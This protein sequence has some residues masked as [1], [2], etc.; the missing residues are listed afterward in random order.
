MPVFHELS[1]FMKRFLP[2]FLAIAALGSLFLANGQEKE[3]SPPE[4][5]R[6]LK[7]LLI[8]GGCCHDYVK[9]HEILFKGIQERANV[10]VDVVWTRDRSTNPP[11]PIYDDPDW[12][13]GYDIIIHDE[14]AANNKD[15]KVMENILAVHKTIPSVHLHCAMHSFR[16]GTDKWPKHLGIHSTGHGPQKPLEITYTNPDHPI[17]KTLKDWTTKNEEL[18]NNHKIY[19]AEPL[20]LATQKNGDRE[21]SAI[22]AW[23][24]TKQ[25]APSFSTTIGHNNYTVEDP[26]Y[27][28]L[29]TRGLLWAAGKLNDDYLKPY[30]GSNLITEMANAAKPVAEAK[31]PK[32][33]TMVKVT[34]KNV[35]TDAGHFPWKAIDGDFSTRWTGNG[36]TMPNWLQLEFQKPTTVTSAEIAWEKRKDWYQ[37][38][39]ETSLDGKS[40]QMA[41]DGS[42]NQRQSDTKDTFEAENI[43]FLRVTVL[44]HQHGQWP[45][46]W[47]L[48][49][50][51]EKGPLKLFPIFEKGKGPKSKVSGKGFEQS[52][53]IKPRIVKLTPEEE[54]AILKDTE[55]PEGFEKTLFAPW[56]TANYPVYVAASP[57]GDLYVSSDGNGSLG[58]QPGRGRVLR[59]R[60]TDQDGRADEVTE[61]IR[62]IDSPRGLIWDHDRLYLLHPPHISVFFDRDGDGVAEES[63][64]LISD[65][66]FG[67]EDR[68]AD[69]TT[70]D[71]TMG[72]DGWIYIA[73]G[74]FGF[75]KATGSDGRTLQHRGGGVIRFRPDGSG[76]ELFATGTRNILATPISPTLDMFARDNTNDG[77]GWDVRFHH[78][79]ALSDHG[80]PRLY[81]NFEKEH[82][83]PLADYGGGSGCGGVYIH[84]P[85]FPAEWNKAPFTCDWGKAGLFRHSVTPDGATFK[86]SA[87]P[88]KF[89]KV[90][91]PTDAD[92]DGMSAVYQASWK[93]PATFN[94]AGPDQGYIVR[95]T[96]KGYK[97]EPLPD[98]E[99]MSDE[100]LVESL[101]SPSQIRRLAIQRT[102]LRRLETKSTNERLLTLAAAESEV[103]EVR[104]AALY[105]VTQ[106]GIQSENSVRIISLILEYLE[107]SN[108]MAPFYTRAYGDMAQDLIT[109]GQVTPIDE[110]LFRW[111]ME[112]KDVLRN[113]EAIIAAARQNK[114][115]TSLALSR[116]PTS[117]DLRIRHTAFQALAKMSAH[118]AAFSMI[119]SDD[120]DTRKAAA[121]ALMRM[122]KPEVVN[123]LLSRLGSEKDLAKRRPL[124]STLARLYHKEAEWKGDS[125]GTRPDTRGPYYQPTT[126]EQS[127]RI[128]TTLKTILKGAEAEEAAFIITKLNKNRIPADDALDRIIDLA[129]KDDKLIPVAITQIAS[130]N[131]IPE[132]ALPLVIKGAK[133]FEAGPAAHS[134]A[135]K[136]LVQSDHP[137]AIAA[138]IQALINID[139]VKGSGKQ[140]TAARGYFLKAPKLENHH[141]ALE[142]LAAERAGT[143]EGNWAAMAVVQLASRKDGSP[144]SREMSMKAIG[145]AWADSKQKIAF[146]NAARDLRN[147]IL[148]ERIRI[149]LSDP[150]KSVAKA[151]KDAAGRLKIQVPGADKTP[152]IAT[153]KPEEAL[154]KI[155]AHKGDLSL[156]EAIFTR[157]TCN[158]CHTVSQN[159]KQKGP[160]L[161]N[162]AETYRRNELVEAIL[163]PNKTIA[164]GFAT[165]VFQLK[166]GKA[167]AGFVTDESG[168]SVTI[169]DISSTEHSFKKSA[170]KDR[171]TLPTSLMPPELMSG[172][173]V[174]EAASLLDY[175]ESL[176][177]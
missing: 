121:W 177:K 4:E 129:L 81:K 60:D 43:K 80:Y 109:K 153:L 45:A 9:Q 154:K 59:L 116:H 159:E 22:V 107:N 29:I 95:V 5:A 86:E 119:D 10:R 37:Y 19:D 115:E 136:I 6:P 104:V 145:K 151:A 57:G 72:I 94:W 51:G 35:Q 101:R 76:L 27:L 68:P 164:Q 74:D 48:K 176:V 97:P 54:A 67:F 92:V 162:I 103:L 114:R 62:D 157:A 91:R 142:K 161:G 47:E 126:W 55:V 117:P 65:I 118:E 152:K 88:Q 3:P 175:L 128:L 169:R 93:G 134:D 63:K 34:A 163:V 132:R 49:L 26:R 131:N 70:N 11:L 89:I 2:L 44:K 25:G 173:T 108:V 28:D 61:F 64:R 99:K 130:A 155:T 150:D 16:N 90:S 42:Q 140:S 111:G 8:A 124:L 82:I 96:P 69:H 156:G 87:E 66:A 148:N 77:G 158:A 13:K 123:E 52:G 174:H 166:D 17:T 133:T 106:R 1:L 58:R 41:Y 100:E 120:I 24:N 33:A 31:P 139:K 85:G 20:A 50:T 165:N 36:P 46:L 15:L 53:N 149:A 7:A 32:D 56:Q 125:W 105:A 38:K 83:H 168:D 160:Y 23:T 40:W 84:E 12:A 113:R 138:A 141:L 78:L 73:G 167:F 14:C 98:F 170:I 135:V 127:E 171:S 147:P 39:I 112:I 110:E 172:F 146:I 71:I 21:S 137:E 79:T 18:Y 144:E 75:V 143:P 102:L 122:H 30:T